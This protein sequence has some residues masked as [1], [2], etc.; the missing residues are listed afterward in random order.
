V[1]WAQARPRTRRAFA[2]SRWNTY[3]ARRR[4]E[5]GGGGGGTNR[6]GPHHS[7]LTPCRIGVHPPERLE[8]RPALALQ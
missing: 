6:T 4:G 7:P 1:A 3:A 2:A 8:P 5:G